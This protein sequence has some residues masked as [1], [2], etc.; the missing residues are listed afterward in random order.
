MAG[1]VTFGFAVIIALPHASRTSTVN[2]KP[3]DVIQSDKKVLEMFP[4]LSL[5]I[6]RPHQN[7]YFKKAICLETLQ[8]PQLQRCSSSRRS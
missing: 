8:E 7:T 1:V 4:L 2:G 3:I 6:H 5:T